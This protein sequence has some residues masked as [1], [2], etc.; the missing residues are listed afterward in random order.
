M[1][2]L[3]ASAGLAL[4]LALVFARDERDYERPGCVSGLLLMEVKR[5]SEVL[6]GQYCG[7][8]RYSR[9]CLLTRWRAADGPFP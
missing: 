3:L 1:R 7:C 5:L 2:T 8:P 6:V 9:A 4:L